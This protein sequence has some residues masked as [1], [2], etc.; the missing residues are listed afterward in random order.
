MKLTTYLR[1]ELSRALRNRS[2]ILFSFVLPGFLYLVFG[3]TQDY[4][5][6]SVHDG[7]VAAV[8]MIGMAM[9]G[10]VV[11]A[12]AQAAG[13]A[14]EF[15]QGWGRQLQLTALRPG[16]FVLVKAV[17]CVMLAA[18]PVIVV[19]VLGVF[20]GASMPLDQWIA[21]AVL[22]W[23]LSAVFALYGLAAGL[24]FPSESAL[25]IATGSLVV[26]AFLGNL[27][28]P[29]SGFMLDLGRLSPLYGIRGL[30]QYPLTRGDL[31][32]TESD[33]L[34]GLV[35]NAVA[36]LAILGVISALAFRRRAGQR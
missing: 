36:W 18:L 33:P 7:N 9:Y 8:I 22:S 17:V 21:S 28:A 27:F 30:A 15:S 31:S 13:A 10:A 14:L 20:T 34:W 25:S 6:V 16:Q 12:T 4:K 3:A 11:A 1:Y 26:W 24:M 2:Q 19:N 32:A 23:L 5:D 35:L 29:L